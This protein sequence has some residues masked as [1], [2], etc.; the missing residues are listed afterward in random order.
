MESAVL[1][2]TSPLD[3]WN[4]TGEDCA[5]NPGKTPEVGDLLAEQAS[6]S[7]EIQV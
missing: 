1:R 7:Q 4:K 6:P 2:V 5:V 3:S